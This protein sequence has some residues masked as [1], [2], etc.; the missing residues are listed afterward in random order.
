MESA[1]GQSSTVAGYRPSLIALP[2]VQA[3]H[4]EYRWDRLGA[5]TVMKLSAVAAP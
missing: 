2:V 4:Y 1:G 3:D 5:L